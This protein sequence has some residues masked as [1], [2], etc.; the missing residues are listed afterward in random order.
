MTRQSL[1]RNFYEITFRPSQN[2]QPSSATKSSSNEEKTQNLAIHN[3]RREQQTCI[4]S[5]DL[6]PSP[7]FLTRNS[8][9]ST[10]INTHRLAKNIRHPINAPNRILALRAL[11]TLPPPPPKHGAIY[12]PRI[13]ENPTTAIEPYRDNA[14]AKVA[15]YR[16]ANLTPKEDVDARVG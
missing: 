14:T 7:I 2:V 8:P 6:I 3:K 4:F 11:S 9:R 1:Q 13:E 16:A 10:A 5:T 15:V 12:C